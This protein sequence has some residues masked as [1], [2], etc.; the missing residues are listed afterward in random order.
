[1]WSTVNNYGLLN[2]FQQLY[3]INP[4][5]FNQVDHPSI[6][7]L[8]KVWSQY[9][10][11]LVA[12]LINKEL[13]AFNRMLGFNIL[14][15]ESYEDI[16]V[17]PLFNLSDDIKLN[18]GYL[19]RLGSITRT[20]VGTTNITYTNDLATFSVT[21]SELDENEYLEFY[22]TSSDGGLPVNQG[23]RIPSV[24]SSYDG[25]GYSCRCSKWVLV[26]PSLQSIYDGY[27]NEVV[28][29]N[30]SETFVTSL[31]V[32]KTSYQIPVL[33]Y[34]DNGYLLDTEM[35]LDQS[36]LVQPCYLY[37]YENL[38]E[39]V[40]P[41]NAVIVNNDYATIRL[42]DPITY[43]GYP[44]KL[45]VYHISGYPYSHRT[46][47]DAFVETMFENLLLR[48]VRASLPESYYQQATTTSTRYNRDLEM[49]DN[50]RLI[51]MEVQRMVDTYKNQVLGSRF[52]G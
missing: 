41:L 11:E 6:D 3:A 48:R 27:I 24:A 52:Y 34:L 30:T 19:N 44:Y 17:T 4:Y 50:V 21:M 22:F 46:T 39:T 13:L 20:L 18:T 10:R 36:D 12:G 42:I 23:Y 40:Y 49:V 1:M 51:D 43:S 5:G 14:P 26:K 45:R 28:L 31:S 37:C 35:S 2:R 33:E 32:Y 29:S 9:D 38:V 16:P 15:M 7:Y 47:A 8:P 25:T